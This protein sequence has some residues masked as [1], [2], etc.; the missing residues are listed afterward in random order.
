MVAMHTYHLNEGHAALLAL[1]ML[2]RTRATTSDRLEQ[3]SQYD[4]TAVRAQCVFTTHTVDRP[5]Q[6]MAARPKGLEHAVRRPR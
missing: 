5:V 6:S 2:A 3:E 4:V 1:E